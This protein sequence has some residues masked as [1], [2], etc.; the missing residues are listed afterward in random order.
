ML[1]VIDLI[2]IDGFLKANIAQFNKFCIDECIGTKGT[3][4][5]TI[6][7]VEN[8]LNASQPAVETDAQKKCHSMHY[9]FKNG[10]KYIFCPICGKDLRIA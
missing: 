1:S 4:P 5:A 3:G 9:G 2:I 8:A 6:K 10:H 7:H